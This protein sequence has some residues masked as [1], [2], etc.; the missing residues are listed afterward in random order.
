MVVSVAFNELCH[1]N[2]NIRHFGALHAETTDADVGDEKCFL[3]F[4]FDFYYETF[5]K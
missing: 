2:I 4:D 1:L 5:R 3:L